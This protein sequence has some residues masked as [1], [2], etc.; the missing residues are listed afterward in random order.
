MHGYALNIWTQYQNAIVKIYF[1][2]SNKP[3]LSTE[4][5]LPIEAKTAKF[6]KAK[7]TLLYEY[8]KIELKAV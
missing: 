6:N 1:S 8:G 3:M 2:A 5:P 4:L 7:K